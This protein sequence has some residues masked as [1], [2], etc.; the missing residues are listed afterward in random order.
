MSEPAAAVV[1]T[2]SPGESKTVALRKRTAS[3]LTLWAAVIG[4]L[5]IG[6][7]P[8]IL[9]FTAVSAL[10]GLYEF[11]RSLECGGLPCDRRAGMITGV[12]FFAVGLPV[13][14][15]YG[16][17]QTM[18]FELIFFIGALLGLC[19]RQLCVNEAPHPGSV[20]RVG[21]TLLGLL[22]TGWMMFYVAK[23]FYLAPAGGPA[24]GVF[25]VFYLLAVT[26][27]S[28]TGAYLLGSRSGSTR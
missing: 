7:A 4:T 6:W 11:Y 25:Y 28:D 9:I 3:T 5:A 8:G 1:V 23:I 12:I 26:K 27:F 10:A 15:I 14:A 18:E 17:L 24:S 13:L 2:P 21:S 16:P 22:Y 19:I 20:A